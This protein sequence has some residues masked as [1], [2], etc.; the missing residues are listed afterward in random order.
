MNI[1]VKYNLKKE[2]KLFKFMFV[3][4]I[5]FCVQMFV[6]KYLPYKRSKI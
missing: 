2:L 1:E 4:F 5:D 3:Y 6:K